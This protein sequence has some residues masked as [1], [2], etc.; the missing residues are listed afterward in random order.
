MPCGSRAARTFLCL[1][2]PAGSGGAAL[3]RSQR[4]GHVVLI[5]RERGIQAHAVR[6][7]RV[8][9]REGRDRHLSRKRDKSSP[10]CNRLL[11]SSDDYRG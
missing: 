8:F 3:R 11:Y 10:A 5:A 4:Y 1:H 9:E 2:R 7:D 6:D